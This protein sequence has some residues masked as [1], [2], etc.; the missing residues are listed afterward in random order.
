MDEERR[1]G[2]NC[3]EGRRKS[4]Y[5]G[6]SPVLWALKNDVKSGEIVMLVDRLA[7]NLI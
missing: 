4:F 6:C 5:G 3:G 2:V 1:R 7:I